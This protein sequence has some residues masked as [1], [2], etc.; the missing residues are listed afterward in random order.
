[1]SDLEWLKEYCEAC[2]GFWLYFPKDDKSMY[3]RIEKKDDVWKA[4]LD[5]YDHPSYFTQ[6][7]HTPKEAVLS[8]MY[9]YKCLLDEKTACIL[10]VIDE[11]AEL[12]QG[13]KE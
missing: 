2:D 7:G 13:G 11:L 5:V 8:A 6:T 3:V 1:M 10:F 12:K 9:S 4:I